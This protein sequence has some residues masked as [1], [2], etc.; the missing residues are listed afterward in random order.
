M[1]HLSFR[2]RV[3]SEAA[4]VVE[5]S[6]LLLYVVSVWFYSPGYHRTQ[7]TLGADCVLVW[8]SMDKAESHFGSTDDGRDSFLKAKAAG[9]TLEQLQY[10]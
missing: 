5:G 7:N 10:D 1:G 3:E 6:T 4:S 9:Y 2:I 8:H